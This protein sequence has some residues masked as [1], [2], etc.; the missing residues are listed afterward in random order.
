MRDS[1]YLLSKKKALNLLRDRN[2]WLPQARVDLRRRLGLEDDEE[3]TKAIKKGRPKNFTLGKHVLS[4]SG[5]RDLLKRMSPYSK[6]NPY[7]CGTSN[8]KKGRNYPFCHLRFTHD[9]QSNGK[10]VQQKKKKPI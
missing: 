7:G 3:S 9:V 6:K 8:Y 5:K 4:K 10:G 1:D 2:K